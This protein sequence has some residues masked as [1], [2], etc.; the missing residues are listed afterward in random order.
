MKE[1][2]IIETQNSIKFLQVTEYM[3]W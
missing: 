2:L 3:T 1:L